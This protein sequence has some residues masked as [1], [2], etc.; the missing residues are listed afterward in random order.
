MLSRHKPALPFHSD[1]TRS[2]L[3][4]AIDGNVNLHSTCHFAL[5]FVDVDGDRKALPKDAL[6]I[7]NELSR[8]NTSNN[9]DADLVSEFIGATVAGID[10]HSRDDEFWAAYHDEASGPKLV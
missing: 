8:R 1:A 6:R 7:I 2:R 3:I 5:P 9:L 10:G 4:E